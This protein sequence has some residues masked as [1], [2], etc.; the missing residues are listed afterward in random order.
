MRRHGEV[1]VAVR[2]CGAD[3]STG[4]AAATPL[5]RSGSMSPPTAYMI[6][7]KHNRVV[8]RWACSVHPTDSPSRGRVLHVGLKKKMLEQLYLG[9]TFHVAETNFEIEKGFQFFKNIC[10]HFFHFFIF[11]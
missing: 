7:R 8:I 4:A 1:A 2:R 9:N 3:A 10:T 5:R 6:D 11:F